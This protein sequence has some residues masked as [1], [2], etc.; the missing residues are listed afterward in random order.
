[1]KYT[2]RQ[3]WP[4]SPILTSEQSDLTCIHGESR[5]RVLAL[6][7]PEYGH[8]QFKSTT[9]GCIKTTIFAT[10]EYL[11]K[12]VA[13][14]SLSN[15]NLARDLV[16]S[17][18]GLNLKNWPEKKGHSVEG[19]IPV[20]PVSGY[21]TRGLLRNPPTY[22]SSPQE[23]AIT[24]SVFREEHD[25]EEDFHLTFSVADADD[26]RHLADM[27]N[28]TGDTWMQLESLFKIKTISSIPLPDEAQP[29][30]E[31]RLNCRD[32]TK[33]FIEHVVDLAKT[34]E[35]LETLDLDFAVSSDI[36]LHR[37]IVAAI[38]LL[39]AFAAYKN[40][41][42][43]NNRKVVLAEIIDNFSSVI[44]AEIAN[45]QLDKVEQRK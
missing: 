15:P 11:S 37:P 6:T 23:P 2:N 27:I 3:E 12:I 18:S 42:Y 35:C 22:T 14:L 32:Y 13:G 41:Q 16:V 17:S 9:E 7:I 43:N 25:L 5:L 19:W 31:K 38:S 34:S 1:M 28:E 36:Q 30:P 39:N 24:L 21:I 20:S 45:T 10:Q 26:M 33:A 8:H 40:A 4:D 44:K 29:Q